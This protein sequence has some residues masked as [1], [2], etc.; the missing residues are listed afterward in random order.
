LSDVDEFLRAQAEEI[1]RRF[2]AV[3]GQLRVEKLRWTV[4][5]FAIVDD[6]TGR[7]LIWTQDVPGRFPGH[8]DLGRSYELHKDDGTLLL[9]RIDADDDVVAVSLR[10]VGRVSLLVGSIVG[11]FLVGSVF[12][13]GVCVWWLRD[14]FV[15][16]ATRCLSLDEALGAGE[17]AEVEFKQDPLDHKGRRDFSGIL[18]AITGFANSNDGTVCIGVEDGGHV[19]GLKIKDRDEAKGFIEA[20]SSAI[21]ERIT[22]CPVFDVHLNSRP[23]GLVAT[24]CV[25]REEGK[26]FCLGGI[27]YVRKGVQTV[28]ARPE[29]IE[30]IRRGR[31]P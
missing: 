15:L 20:M 8:L 3:H 9:V 5:A 24:I 14:Y 12:V 25:P 26:L 16:K 21:R 1:I 29:E 13:Y 28:P 18:K 7:V 17:N 23:E 31:R 10:S 27:F 4:D 6:E 22:P 11:I 30:R 19:E 2:Q